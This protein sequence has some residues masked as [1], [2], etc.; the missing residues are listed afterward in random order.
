MKR[1]HTSV[2]DINNIGVSGEQH[3]SNTRKKTNRQLQLINSGPMS[4]R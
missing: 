4:L 1:D 2:K 3:V